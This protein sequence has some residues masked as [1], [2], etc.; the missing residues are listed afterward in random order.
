MYMNNMYDV[1]LLSK[2]FMYQPISVP[3]RSKA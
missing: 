2:K 1:R 3:A